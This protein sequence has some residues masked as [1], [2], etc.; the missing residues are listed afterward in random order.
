M[1]LAA[2]LGRKSRKRL[3]TIEHLHESLADIRH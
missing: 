2:E 1:G 3:E